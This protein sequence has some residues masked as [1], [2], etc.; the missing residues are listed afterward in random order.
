MLDERVRPP[1]AVKAREDAP[2]GALD[3]APLPGKAEA[4]V[5][6][7]PLCRYSTAFEVAVLVLRAGDREQ[8]V[9]KRATLFAGIRC[10]LPVRENQAFGEFELSASR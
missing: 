6:V 8:A 5:R 4:L 10:K 9:I 7:R 1:E 3:D 2:L